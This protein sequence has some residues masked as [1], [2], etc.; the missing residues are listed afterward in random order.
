MGGNWKPIIVVI[1]VAALAIWLVAYRDQLVAGMRGLVDQMSPA[2]RATASCEGFVKER[3]KAPS[4]AKFSNEVTGV[5]GRLYTVTG[6]VDAQ[7]SFGAMLR[8]KYNC[9][10]T[11]DGTLRNLDVE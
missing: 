11:K 1:L 5:N 8:S 3:L 4:T 9:L 6:D 7:N 2:K 10:V